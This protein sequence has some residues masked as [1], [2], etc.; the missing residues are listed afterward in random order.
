MRSKKHPFIIGII[1]IFIFSIAFL[2]A[3]AAT[4]TVTDCASSNGNANRLEETIAAA[5]SG[6][7]IEFSCGPATI[8]VPQVMTINK[9]LTIDGGDTIILDGA[10]LRSIFSI[11]SGNTV[12][13]RNIDLHNAYNNNGGGITNAI[14]SSVTITNSLLSGNHAGMRGALSAVTERF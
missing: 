12:Y 8:N 2:P 7:T 13:L 4:L 14:S 6:D 5:S 11:S 3:Q 9:N 1:L 10:D